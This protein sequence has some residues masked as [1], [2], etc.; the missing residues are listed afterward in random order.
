MAKM[1][2][3]GSILERL[4]HKYR[5]VVL[6]DDTME[7]QFS[8]RLSQMNI[9]VFL[10]TLTVL[11]AVFTVVVMALTPLKE[12]LPGYDDTGTRRK[13]YALAEKSDSLERVVKQQNA[14]INSVQQVLEEKNMANGSNTP[15][16][17]E[18]DFANTEPAEMEGL[19]EE[20]KELRRT[21]EKEGQFT[22]VGD[23]NLNAQRLSQNQL[24]NL[25]APAKGIISAG[26]DPHK[27]HFAVDIVT[28]AN[29]PVKA[30]ASGVVI[31]A[32]WTHE[33]GYVLGIQHGN[34]LMSFYKHNA[35]LLKKTGT[36]VKAGDAIA[37]VGNS[38]EQTVG[39]HLH[40]ELWHNQSPLNPTDYL[41][42]N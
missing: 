18:P 11:T 33:S 23:E 41:D 30:T 14:F 13:V 3:W 34:N 42:F 12:Y 19:S 28:A 4:K 10:S 5:L 9:Y 17:N 37:I 26:Y 21:M 16:Q 22:T 8:F 2:N 32:D 38:G 36:F 1:P 6:T 20:E 15:A 25:F 35:A 31:L 40:F 39:P 27:E 7:E 29:E 24:Y